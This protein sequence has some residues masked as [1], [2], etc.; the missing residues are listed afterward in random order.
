MALVV[1]NSPNNG[2]ADPT[3]S[4]KIA[5]VEFENIL[6]ADQKKRYHATSNALDTSTVISFAKTLDERRQG[7][8]QRGVSSRLITFLDSLQ[9]FTQIVD[10]FVSSNPK[11]AALVW[12]GAKTAILAANNISS[13]FDKVTAMIMNIGK[14]YPTYQ[15]FGH[16]YSGCVE[17][18]NALC[19]YYAA[20]IRLCMKIVIVSQRSG[21]LHT[22]SSA[23]YSFESEFSAN[24]AELHQ[25]TD[26]VKLQ[27]ALA[28]KKAT[29]EAEKLA[30]V[31]RRENDKY[32][33]LGKIFQSFVTKDLAEAREWRLRQ[34][35]RETSQMRDTVCDS[36]STIN[37]LR[38]WKRVLQQRIPST[39]EWFQ[40][41]A[42]F[43]SWRNDNDSAIIWC[44]GTMGVGKTV[45]MSSIVEYLHISRAPSETISHHFCMSDDEASLKARNI[46]GSIARQILNPWIQNIHKAELRDLCQAT[47]NAN[48]AEIVDLLSS[49]M[50]PN[51]I[52]N[53]VVDGVDE[54]KVE[55]IEELM[56]GLA[57]LYKRH[58]KNIKVVFASRP[59]Q[60]KVFRRKLNIKYR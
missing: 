34:L 19:E 46:L 48:S 51:H 32:R 41:D 20:V 59:D 17:L 2:V 60:E 37:S 44:V 39:A 40:E 52:H 7:A 23:F 53:I 31:D 30:A 3:S 12:G 15:S 38:L 42:T 4:L 45:L 27:C 56:L 26:F 54:C 57:S 29:A 1:S 28:S 58:S 8:A 43:N 33:H 25:A 50:Q 14:I 24:I 55:E 5:L 35:Q 13:Y 18:Q 21:L 47:S 49:R 36:M 16:L 11:I 9:R 22:L 6:S 10:T